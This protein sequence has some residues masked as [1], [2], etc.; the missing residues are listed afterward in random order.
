MSPLNSPLKGLRV[1]LRQLAS[2]RAQRWGQRA[3][4][5][6][7]SPLPSI[8]R[9]CTLASNGILILERSF[10]D[11][12]CFVVVIGP[13]F[14]SPMQARDASVAVS[15]PEVECFIFTQVLSRLL[16]REDLHLSYATQVHGYIRASGGTDKDATL[17]LVHGVCFS[18]L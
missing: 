9:H 2:R 6:C 12:L 4:Q 13:M 17:T 16:P 1:V 3:L 7:R 5:V 11:V 14:T 15:W 10:L 8:P 18:Q